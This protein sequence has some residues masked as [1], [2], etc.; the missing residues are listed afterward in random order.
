MSLR[1][2]TPLYEQGVGSGRFQVL[3]GY[4]GLC[5]VPDVETDRLRGRRG[6]ERGTESQV[7][8]EV[9]PVVLRGPVGT[10]VLAEETDVSR[11][12]AVVTVIHHSLSPAG[13]GRD[14][15]RCGSGE[16]GRGHGTPT[17]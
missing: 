12:R 17:G 1:G 10:E 8:V 7:P 6:E 16:V 14:M 2:S 9:V 5:R 13:V 15:V 11:R 4:P 3:D